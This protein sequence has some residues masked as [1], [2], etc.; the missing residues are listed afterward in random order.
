MNAAKELVG[1]VNEAVINPLILLLFAA[2]TLLF[3]WGVAQFLF[4]ASQSGE[5]DEGKRHMLWGVIGMAIMIS[6]YGILRV[7]TT[8]FGVDCPG[9]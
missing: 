6:V 3:L 8:T 1:R 7:I 9:C 4:T 2:A 5:Q